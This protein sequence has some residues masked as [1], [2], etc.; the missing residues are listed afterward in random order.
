MKNKLIKNVHDET[1]INLTRIKISNDLQ[2]NE[3]IDLLIYIYDSLDDD[4]K[5]D[6]IETYY[7]NEAV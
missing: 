1:W 7:E 6:L 4:F 3:T 5:S 2:V